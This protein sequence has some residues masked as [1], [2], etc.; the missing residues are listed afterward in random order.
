MKNKYLR[1]NLF[2]NLKGGARRTVIARA[3]TSADEQRVEEQRAEQRANEERANEERAQKE[4]AWQRDQL[5][6]E[7]ITMQNELKKQLDAGDQPGALWHADVADAHVPKAAQRAEEQIEEEQIAEQRAREQ[8]EQREQRAAQNELEFLRRDELRRGEQEKRQKWKLEAN[9]EKIGVMSSHRRHVKTL[10]GRDISKL[11]INTR[12]YQSYG[13][14]DIYPN[15]K[16]YSTFNEHDL[17]YDLLILNEF[18]TPIDDELHKLSIEMYNRHVQKWK[19]QDI[20]KLKIKTRYYQSYGWSD[21]Y[22][23]YKFYSTFNEHDRTYNLLILNERGIPIDNLPKIQQVME[24][25]AENPPFPPPPPQS[26]G[27][28]PEPPPSDLY[29][30]NRRC[31]KI[32]KPS[33]STTSYSD[34]DMLF[35]EACRG[36]NGE[37]YFIDIYHEKDE[38]LSI[39]HTIRNVEGIEFCSIYEYIQCKKIDIQNFNY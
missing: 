5:L 17:T 28:G 9:E 13:V 37:I 30:K 14:S 34:D 32:E 21:I 15:Y 19:Y 25:S 27:S 38:D 36:L 26:Q 16:F 18:D 4:I 12:Y 33:T 11:K 24:A 6:R 22:P 2:S 3:I 23:N 29:L 20:I 1:L 7:E 35:L 8:K 10:S 31:W 39:I